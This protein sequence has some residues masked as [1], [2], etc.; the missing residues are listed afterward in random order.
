LY[1]YVVNPFTKESY[2]DWAEFKRDVIFAER[3]MD[4]IVD[5]EL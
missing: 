3:M 5:L 4:D 2:F 1:G